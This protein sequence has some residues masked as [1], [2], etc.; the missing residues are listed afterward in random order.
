MDSLKMELSHSIKRFDL[1]PVQRKLYSQDLLKIPPVLKRL[2][3]IP[4]CVVQPESEKEVVSVLDF[5]RKHKIPIVPRG[6]ATSAYGGATVLKQCIV[7]DFTR[8]NKLEIENNRAVV[9]SGAVWLD[10]EKELN[11]VGLALRVYPSSAPSSTIGGWIAQG[12]YG[13]GSLKYGGILENLEWLEVA[14]F[15]GIRKV[16]KNELKNFVGLFGSTGLIVRACLS[17]RKNFEIRSV[18]VKTNFEKTLELLDGAYHATFI[19]S[20]LGRMLG[21]SEDDVLLLS[22]EGDP[23]QEGDGYLGSKMWESR[24]DLFRAARKSE[25]IFTEAVLPYDSVADF[26]EQAGRIPVK[27]IFTRNEAVVLGIVPVEG[28]YS[29]A[30][31]ALKFIK[32]AER[33]GGRTYA[34]GLLFPH[35][36]LA[37]D[38]VREYKK[39]IDPHNLLNP[40]K[41]IQANSFSRLIRV[42]ELIL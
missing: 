26:I 7:V 27:V 33:Y 17:L 4:V 38:E 6:A 10:V 16:R 37:D 12:G 23:I 25:I 24:F 22:Y 1:H 8:M 41:A 20:E 18:A 21:C 39:R 29:A 36:G 30:L 35:K 34:S 28:Y 32:V 3:K 40:G 15:E 2:V 9:E 14:D 19:N 31:K 42:A 13:I 5:A 11:K